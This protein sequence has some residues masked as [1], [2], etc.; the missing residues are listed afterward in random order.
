[1]IELTVPPEEFA[2]VEDVQGAM[3]E[4]PHGRD[5]WPP[6]RRRTGARSND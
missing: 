4:L 3:E 2:R 1:V 6:D 5:A